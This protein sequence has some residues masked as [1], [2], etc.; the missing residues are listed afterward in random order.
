MC[1]VTCAVPGGAR[2]SLRVRR[3]AGARRPGAGWRTSQPPGRWCQCVAFAGLRPTRRTAQPRRSVTASM[4]A[5]PMWWARTVRGRWPSS[6]SRCAR[7]RVPATSSTPRAAAASGRLG[8]TGW[9]R[10]RETNSRHPRHRVSGDGCRLPGSRWRT[11]HCA[12]QSFV[13]TRAVTP[14]TRDVSVRRDDRGWGPGAGAPGGL[15]RRIGSLPGDSP[16]GS[17]DA[18]SGRT[19]RWA[20]PRRGVL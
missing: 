5:V 14:R 13:S 3:S 4:S 8:G 1:G 17:V 11:F 9:Q 19:V 6:A 10:R 15:P 16:G 2:V 12:G 7:A 18:A 20:C